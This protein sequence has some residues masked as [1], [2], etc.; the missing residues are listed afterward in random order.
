MPAAVVCACE[1]A[2]TAE[3]ANDAET[4]QFNL[5]PSA[6]MSSVAAA[7]ST[8]AATVQELIRTLRSNNTPLSERLRLGRSLWTS[9]AV[10]VPGKTELLLDWIAALLVKSVPSSTTST[11]TTA[12]ADVCRAACRWAFGI[13]AYQCISTMWQM[14]LDLLHSLAPQSQA[15]A[16]ISTNAPSMQ[17]KVPL[18]PLFAAV[19]RASPDQASIQLLPL[20]R[21]VFGLTT[22]SLAAVARIS[23]D[24]LASLGLEI[25]QCL[26]SRI[27]GS[28]PLSP[29]L[30]DYAIGILE[31]MQQ[32]QVKS[33]HQK[34]IFTFAVQKQVPVLIQLRYA[35]LAAEL[36]EERG[37]LSKSQ[38]ESFVALFTSIIEDVV[39]HSDHLSEF[40]SVLQQIASRRSNSAPGVASAKPP[41]AAA[42]AAEV[43]PSNVNAGYP[44][45]LLDTL[46]S[47]AQ[48]A[49]TR[50]ALVAA[51]PSLFRSFCLAF[52]S[53]G[54]ASLFVPTAFGMFAEKHR[55]LLL[56]V[57]AVG[58]TA[59]ADGAA[60]KRSAKRKAKSGDQ[61]AEP[62]MS[63][64]SAIQSQSELSSLGQLLR[65]LVDFDIF[66]A[67]N[68]DISVAQRAYLEQLTE[69][70]AAWLH[71]LRL[72]YTLIADN[73]EDVW[74][75]VFVP[76]GPS[77]AAA[78]DL[79][80]DLLSVFVKSR[81]LDSML[82]VVL[83]C[84]RQT[85]FCDQLRNTC[86]LDDRWMSAFGG[87]ISSILSAQS[88]AIIQLLMDE[89]YASYGVDVGSSAAAVAPASPDASQLKKK[90]KTAKPNGDAS[91][92]S[93]TPAS[94]Q[95]R[96]SRL[97]VDLLCTC[98]VH[99]SPSDAQHAALLAQINGFYDGYV[100]PCL[101][102]AKSHAGSDDMAILV[103]R[104]I[105]P[106]L[107]LHW[108]L[109]RISQDYWSAH[110][111]S[112]AVAKMQKRFKKLLP[113]YP[114]LQPWM[115]R[116]VC[117]HATRLVSISANPADEQDCRSIIHKL[118]DS[119]SLSDMSTSTDELLVASW[120]AILSS[121][122]SIGQIAAPAYLVRIV[123]VFVASLQHQPLSELWDGKAPLSTNRLSAELLL[124]PPFYEITSVH[125][126]LLCALFGSLQ[127]GL[128]DVFGACGAAATKIFKSLNE[129]QTARTA[130]SLTTAIE[131]I[132][133]MVSQ[134]VVEPAGAPSATSIKS[135]QGALNLLEALSLFPTVYFTTFEREAIVI[136]IFAVEWLVAGNSGLQAAHGRLFVRTGLVCRRLTLRFMRSREDKLLT[137]Y[138]PTIMS[139]YLSFLGKY[140]ETTAALTS[141][142]G[143]DN[144]DVRTWCAAIVDETSSIV[145]LTTRKVV[146]RL[147][148]GSLPKGSKT[149]PAQLIAAMWPIL[150]S[151]STIFASKPAAT[152]SKSSKKSGKADKKSRPAAAPTTPLLVPVLP[153]STVPIT[154]AAGSIAA[155]GDL[156]AHDSKRVPKSLFTD[157]QFMNLLAHL[158][159]AATHADTVRSYPTDSAT[160]IRHLCRFF[161]AAG[162]TDPLQRILH[163]PCRF[164][165]MPMAAFDVDAESIQTRLPGWLD[166]CWHLYTTSPDRCPKDHYAL[167][168]ANHLDALAAA[169]DRLSCSTDLEPEHLGGLLACFS[170]LWE[171]PNQHSA[172]HLIRALLPR[173]LTMCATV[174]QRSASLQTL[175]RVLDLANVVVTDRRIDLDSG[176]VSMVLGILQA[177]MANSQC[178]A[179]NTKPSALPLADVPPV[180][181]AIF[182]NMYRVL[183]GLLRFR[184]EA[185]VRQIP[186][187]IA[188]ICA[189]LGAFQEQPKLGVTGSPGDKKAAESTAPTASG[190]SG[191]QSV[192]A[193]NAVRL[194]APFAPMPVACAKSLARVM[195]AITEKPAAFSSDAASASASGAS[196]STSHHDLSTQHTQLVK[197]FS[198]H[199]PFLL[200][201]IVSIQASMRP[202]PPAVK[203]A[204]REGVYAL[205]DVCNDH[206]RL[207]VLA[208]L[209]GGSHG[210][211]FILKDFVAGWEK[212]HR[213]KGKA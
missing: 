16:P 89:M 148:V 115:I 94:L 205:L 64:A 173:L 117:S 9:H 35:V 140:C 193:T 52:R 202:F 110:V 189:L 169:I 47:L 75:L 180:Y 34:K 150:T 145:E 111:S 33:P 132:F 123:E 21:T 119:V 6:G 167:L 170:L 118:L 149:N 66:R 130:A 26:L 155:V 183:L 60:K 198:K 100:A 139:A 51:L 124:Y 109:I 91:V 175:N 204:L 187:F 68:D 134:S 213:Y 112:E 184:R 113:T 154:V 201:R 206:G 44:R 211:R 174:G 128:E 29:A 15:S 157:P 133:G 106:A 41:S 79:A 127:T 176:E 58:S 97:I 186:L 42:A 30:W 62:L 196:A 121:M 8:G 2:K 72:D 208:G 59:D 135:L 185:I 199:A 80:V 99:A 45:A 20:A 37:G 165:P 92:A 126:S 18:A 122:F 120:Q 49:N 212:D 194:F 25:A 103:E 69:V 101:E 24:Q 171:T 85:P 53:R 197:P 178:T 172:R 164:M 181:L 40:A 142:D 36:A 152:P 116:I 156:L 192:F 46:K 96:D 195:S 125:D 136:A 56:P 105:C 48:S 190:Q 19:A 151:T 98:L 81:Q 90:R 11:A 93:A 161:K 203:D 138:D 67:G 95:I 162:Q 166:D 158:E 38:T 104:R 191:G 102:L 50:P 3:A 73:L 76:H 129:L 63:A 55:I 77:R 1:T 74:R 57:Q 137:F 209:D 160:V 28:Q 78:V 108:T 10:Y 5:K 141:V 17:L 65:L 23:T 200:S 179:S 159:S 86:L 82:R 163:V 114:A 22:G 147:E 153:G 84:A 27:A 143:A 7:A 207:A 107:Q 4:A 144:S 14:L 43:P 13:H 88:I 188:P 61:P 71:L 39:L 210:G 182:E 177:V 83:E 12:A 168:V 87:F 131:E 31:K 146:Q 70:F 32:E 54:K